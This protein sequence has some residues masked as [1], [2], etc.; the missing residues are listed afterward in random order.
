MSPRLGDIRP[1]NWPNPIWRGMF[2]HGGGQW[3]KRKGRPMATHGTSSRNTLS[4]NSFQRIL[5]TSQDENSVTLWMQQMTTYAYMW[6]LI[7]NS[8]LRFNI[9]MSWTMCAILWWGFRLGPSTSLRRIGPFHYS[10]P[11]WKWKVFP[12]WD[13]VKS[14]GSRRITISL[15]RRHTKKGNGIEGKTPRKGKNLNNFKVR[16]LNPKG[17]SSR[18]EFYLKG[19]NLRGMLAGSP[20]E[21]VSIVMK[22]GTTPN[23]TPN[24]N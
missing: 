6:R 21:R 23:I 1:W 20:K 22:W 15:T 4:W 12:M 2:P 16:V 7:P 13:G 10:K 3:N 17:I 8:C 19:A 14:S 5:I 11:S 9:C 24:P 18:R